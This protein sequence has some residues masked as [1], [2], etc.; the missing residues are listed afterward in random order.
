SWWGSWWPSCC[1]RGASGEGEQAVRSERQPE[2]A[3]D[4]HA[5]DLAGAL[6]DLEDLGV[7]VEAGHR[8]LVHEPVAAEDLGGDAGGAHGRLGALQLGHGR[9]TGERAA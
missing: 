6:P 2:V 4:H 3:S 9:L 8:R 7:P 5:L 1:A